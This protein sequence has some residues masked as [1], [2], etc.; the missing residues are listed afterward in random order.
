MS[1]TEI[2]SRG[3]MSGRNVLDRGATTTN[4]GGAIGGARLRM[5]TGPGSAPVLAWTGVADGRRVVRAGTVIRD[6]D[7]IQQ[8]SPSTTDAQLLDMGA[9]A[10]GTAVALWGTHPA[11]AAAAAVRPADSA[12]FGP[13]QLV[14]AGTD[15]SFNGAVA[16]APNGGASV[17]GGPEVVLNRESPPPVMLSTLP[18]G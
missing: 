10:A 15:A 6:V 8:L 2:D 3:T 1:H 4:E 11:T 16:V 18:A 7:S 5:V 9:N 12:Q 17:V 13:S 14:F